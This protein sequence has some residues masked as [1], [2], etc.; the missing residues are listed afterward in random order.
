M[1][2]M[3]S[4]LTGVSIGNWTVCSDT[5]QRKHQS[6]A[7]LAFVRG[8]HRWPVNSPHK[9]PVT[10]KMFPFDDVNHIVLPK[11]VYWWHN[12]KWFTICCCICFCVIFKVALKILYM[13]W[14]P[15]AI[16]NQ[17]VIFLNAS[18]IKGHFDRCRNGII[19]LQSDVSRLELTKYTWVHEDH[20][21]LGCMLRSR[22]VRKSGTDFYQSGFVLRWNIRYIVS[23]K[24]IHI[25]IHQHWDSRCLWTRSCLRLVLECMYLNDMRIS[26]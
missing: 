18:L 24:Y 17:Y 3:A 2:V 1:S 21:C 23:E 4:Q 25:I 11:V 6:S 7:S 10:R 26:F 22:R 20:S 9:G 19:V 5:D 16:Y 15:R 14:I 12:V 13:N 8:I